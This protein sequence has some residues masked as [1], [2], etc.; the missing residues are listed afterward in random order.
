MSLSRQSKKW[1]LFGAV[2]LGLCYFALHSSGKGLS[3]NSSSQN[4]P[5]CSKNN[6]NASAKIIAS[7]KTVNMSPEGK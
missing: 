4:C 1:L 7:R 3:E 5:E 2:I 6:N